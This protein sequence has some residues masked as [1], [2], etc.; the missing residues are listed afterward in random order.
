MARG[1]GLWRGRA[2][3]GFFSQ[4]KKLEM[5]EDMG[6]SGWGFCDF[7]FVGIFVFFGFG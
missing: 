6:E 7:Y 1:D 2:S 4:C 5:A 3:N